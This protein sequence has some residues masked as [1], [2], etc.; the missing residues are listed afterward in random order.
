[1]QARKTL[2]RW[3]LMAGAAAALVGG[4]AYAQRNTCIDCEPCGCSPDGGY[5][6]CCSESAC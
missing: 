1:M 2:Y 6:L 4:V 5:I 3:M